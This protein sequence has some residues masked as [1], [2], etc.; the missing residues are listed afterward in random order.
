MGYNNIIG[1][2]IGQGSDIVTAFQTLM[3]NYF[4][5]YIDT[6]QPV[7]VVSVNEDNTVNVKPLLQDMTTSGKLLEITDDDIIY[8]IPVMMLTGSN[9]SLVFNVDTGNK[10][11]LLACQFDISNFKETGQASP[12][13]TNR[14]YSY[15]DGFYLPLT[16]LNTKPETMILTY[17]KSSISIKDGQIDVIGGDNS[18]INVTAKEVNVTADVKVTGNIEATG[19]VKAGNISLKNHIHDFDYVGAGQGSSPQS[20][21]TQKP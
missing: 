18:T 6:V 1:G 15:S 14:T 21:T 2:N 10:G 4:M 3:K 12:K 5:N 19:D 11:L 20:G 9:C 7:E 16:I 17:G 8:N 13:K